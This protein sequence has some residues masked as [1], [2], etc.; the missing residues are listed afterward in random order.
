MRVPDGLR[1]RLLSLAVV[2]GVGLAAAVAGAQ[3]AAPERRPVAEPGVD[4]YGGDLRAIY[5]TTLPVCRD[6][7]LADGACVGFTFNTAAAACFLKSEIGERRP[8]S[9]AL[10]ARLEAMPPALRATAAMR[11]AELGFLPPQALA[12]ARETAL[13]GGFPAAVD[14]A[15][16]IATLRAGAN[17]TDAAS[18]WLRLATA[19]ALAHTEDGELRG[20]LRA[21]AAAAAVNAFLRAPDDAAAAE[22]ARTL[23]VALESRGEGRAGLGA[24]RLAA[25]LA[26]G[27]AV[28]AELARAEG[29]YGFR[30]VDRQV[31][32]EPASPR[33]CFEFSEDLAATGVDYGDFLR[34]AGGD[35]P[36]AA[37]GRRLCVEGL[38]H[39]AR[40]AVTL[41]A[42]LPSA[43]GEALP[44][45]IEQDVYVRDRSPAAR[46]L[47][48]AYV[49]PRSPDAAVPIS[50]VNLDE[51]ALRLHRV[52]ARS[53]AAVVRDGD[54]G[55][56]LTGFEQERLGADLGEAIWE[57][58]GEI[59][60]ELN[61][62]VVT[63]L[64]LG[65]VVAGL[66]PGLYAV[67]ARPP[68]RAREDWETLPTQWFVV[69]D[70]GL[71]AIAGA[72]G[73][74]V[75][76]RGLSDALPRAGA[77]VELVARNNELL[78][79]ATTDAAG[80][81][82]F[83][84]GLLRGAGGAEPA[85]A[86]VADASDDFAFL[87]LIEPGFD[88]SDRGVEGRPAPP[89]VDVFLAAERGAY[90]PGET[91][92]AT[93]LARDARARAVEGLPLT[94]IVTRPDGVEQAR[95][96][97]P[98]EGAG[99]RSLAL[100][101]APGAQRGGWRLGIHADPDA[102]AL[103]TT[104]F[105]VED[106]TPER[107]DLAL[108]APDGP[109]D[110]SAGLTIM[111]QVDYLFGAPGAGLPLEG[112][113]EV[114]PGRGLPGFDGYVFG[115]EDEPFRSEYAA[116]PVGLG[117]DADGAAR[118]EAITPAA[119]P[120]TRP[121]ELT[122]T[123]RVR[124]GSGRPVERTLSRPLRPATPLIGLRPL[125]DGAVDEGGTA[126]F[127][128]LAVGP[129][130]ARA[131]FGPAEWTLS[132]VETT[133]QW[134]QLD[135]DWT[136]EPITRRVRTASGTVDLAAGAPARIDL[137]VDW[138]RYELRLTAPDGRPIATSVGFDAGWYAAAGGAETPDFIDVG[139]DRAGYGPG[140][141]ARA[142]IEARHPGR[143]L[144][145]VVSDRLIEVRELAV[146]AGA[147]VVDL[148]VTEAW[149]AGAYVV[150][151]LIRPMDVAARR[152]PARAIGLAWAAVDPGPRRLVA[153]FDVPAEVSPRSTL[154]VAL[155]IGG[156]AP[157]EAAFAT[158][159]AVDVGVLN[160]TGYAAPDPGA[161]YFGQR[162]LGVEMRDLY[163]RLIDG[164]QGAQGR[165]RSGGD[166]GLAM[167]GP[168]PTQDLVAVF[169]GVLRADPD[170]VVRL[171]A[172]IPDF[173]GTV[174]LMAVAW[175]A[176]GV[177]QATADVLARDPVV[178]Q[179][180][181]PRFLAPG[182]ASRLRLDLAHAF[183]PAGPVTIRVDASDPALLPGAAAPLTGE[184]G[185]RG[186]LV[187]ETPLAAGPPGDYRLTVET[188]TPGGARL[189]QELRLAVRAND[190]AIA[191]QSRIPLAAGETLILDAAVFDGLAPGTARATLAA[192]PLA[193]F[194]VPGLLAG[195]EAYPWGCSEQIASRA[196]PLLYFAETARGLGLASGAEADAR[197]AE[198]IAGVLANQTGAG[199]FGLWAAE[200]G[201]PWLDAYVTDFL[202]RA[203]S[204]GHAV[205]DRA[206]DAALGAL[207]NLVN[208]YGDFEDGGA[209]LAYALMV[210][211]REGR[212]AIGDLRYYADA[213]ADAF[214]TPFAQAQVGL[215]LAMYGDQPRADAM[216]ARASAGALA[217]EA[218]RTFRA[219]FGS[220]L[221]DAA[222]VLALAAEA[223]SAAADQPALAAL[224]AAPAPA[225][226]P[227]ESLWTLL[228]AQA[229][230]DE[231][232]GRG[233]L[234]LDGVPGDG[235]VARVLEADVL[236]AEPLRVVN[237]GPDDTLVVVTAFGV[238][239][240][241]EPAG[242][243]GYRIERALFTLDGTPAD[244]AA[245]ALNDRLVAVVTVTPERDVEARLIVSDPLPAGF[246]ID[247]PNLLRSGEPGRLA[248]LAADDVA[249]HVE[250]RAD[251]FVAAVD[252]SGTAP[253]RLAYLVRAVSPGTF[254]RPAA[255]VEDMYRP[256][257]RA[258]TEAGRVDIRAPG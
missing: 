109:V 149:G 159:A 97:L 129:D 182:D 111:A 14:A 176:E 169:S 120:T 15:P 123:V 68:G 67:T 158:I 30:V 252:W 21:E 143:A 115:L 47:G 177:G 41:R 247:N 195:L 26:P 154:P 197:I 37:E 186:R 83:D 155:R 258:R 81:A 55:G 257:Y 157:G 73:L 236:G 255:S 134:Y 57:G 148:P 33:A 118:I 220:G 178:V 38:A 20:R 91:V 23:A 79:T 29:L 248:W 156:L 121:L 165:V 18:D 214:S 202:S 112:E 132:R 32:F 150:A 34:V 215:A 240:Q 127:E 138:G 40:Y 60:A 128:A 192:G 135:G 1:A 251:R 241:P 25:R 194:D 191:R 54:F 95:I 227:Q 144:V 243:D 147:T 130:L 166:G 189:A 198:A 42:G 53:L 225:R 82:R 136:Y 70:L 52:G 160:L 103:A 108:S 113:T 212:A 203:R 58:T 86:T 163:G 206:F 208:A 209:D 139:L 125:F 131:A 179:A 6:A 244:P 19:A 164:M 133:F 162:R 229:L 145:A 12:A 62:D 85:L 2:A 196:M 245:V 224:V 105:L 114:R 223:G 174:R 98:D 102:P 126:R 49:L 180:S 193:D 78:G 94:A 242:G 122:A 76:V 173:N 185:E 5:A 207:G 71:A 8:F 256:A 142:R 106:F 141:V 234:T 51:V 183:G 218:E 250:F 64:P 190:P 210:L 168:P 201:D 100:P 27:E 175:T 119:W 116:L 24:L 222:G 228:A 124:E 205:P 140:E 235:P 151:T 99:G 50:T 246:E 28:A 10:S 46:F 16:G 87:S 249:R 69:T 239:T 188:T 11:A 4:F 22:A 75:F 253:F 44:R 90:R 211:A 56:A 89:P 204:L 48:R 231:A 7:C 66:A 199:G 96:V 237:S 230:V 117:T 181:L 238:P 216:F 80:Y 232:R 43:A 45:P 152:N 77:T 226:S 213:R 88:L 3:E 59:A 219:D 35:F 74:H 13:A 184:L 65:P 17:A 187:F 233:A 110:A 36:V 254:R 63:A 107:L 221:R 217:G 146:E 61:R 167:R 171:S 39:G 72:D 170:G 101:I 161:W 104:G 172:P 137:P 93:V 200:G 9:A 153:T 92:Y 31:E 84:P